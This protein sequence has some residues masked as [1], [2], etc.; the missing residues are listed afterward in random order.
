[1]ILDNEPP[2]AILIFMILL[3]DLFDCE[4]LITSKGTFWYDEPIV[5]QKQGFL[6]D[7]LSSIDILF[8]VLIN[9]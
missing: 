7:I 2:I 9:L 5:K 6:R 8:D 4:A 3:N 1:M